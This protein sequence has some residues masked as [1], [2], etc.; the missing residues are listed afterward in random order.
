M[1]K[2]FCLLTVLIIPTVGKK[3]VSP[4]VCP[5]KG[6]HTDC[7]CSQLN[8]ASCTHRTGQAMTL[9]GD[10]NKTVHDRALCI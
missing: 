7:L 9:L 10:N 4:H 5:H 1:I 6:S 8:C 2:H 3:I